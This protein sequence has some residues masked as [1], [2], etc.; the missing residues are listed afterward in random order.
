VKNRKS[1]F[2]K[3]KFAFILDHYVQF[4]ILTP[5]IIREILA[6]G[7]SAMEENGLADSDIIVFGNNGKPVRARTPNQRVLLDESAKN[8]LIFA[9]GPA[10][11]RKTYT[12]IALAVR[13][14]KTRKLK[15]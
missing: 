11:T 3:R 14:L 10:G 15:K 5:D 12:A 9:I 6:S 8:D 4:N 7:I 13:A 1:G 2:L